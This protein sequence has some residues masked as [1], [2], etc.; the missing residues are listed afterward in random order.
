M[1]QKEKIEQYEK[2]S[3]ERAK[4]VA[5]TL[6]E[7]KYLKQEIEELQNK[8]TT[9]ELDNSKYSIDVAELTSS[10]KGFRLQVE[11]LN[12]YLDKANKQKEELGTSLNAIEA[13]NTELKAAVI[14]Q[15]K[16]LCKDV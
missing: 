10:N 9:I 3:I 6:N 5:S 2:Q 11:D 1:T 7:L 15:A 12:K 4:L 14:K 16:L 13:E 8:Y